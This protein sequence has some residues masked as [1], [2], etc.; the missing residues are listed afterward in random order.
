MRK[1]KCLG[2]QLTC[3]VKT[4]KKLVSHFSY[5]VLQPLPTNFSSGTSNGFVPGE[6]QG[7]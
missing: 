7:P 5:N 1:K 6:V 3:T 2:I 4:F